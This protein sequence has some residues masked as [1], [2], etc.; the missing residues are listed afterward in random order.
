M[1]SDA[2]SGQYSSIGSIPFNPINP[3]TFFVDNTAHT[4]VQSYYYKVIAVD[5]C[6]QDS[7]TSDTV[8]TIYLTGKVNDDISNTLEFNDYEVWLGGVNHYSLFRTVDGVFDGN[9]ADVAKG[10]NVVI[11]DVSDRIYTDGIFC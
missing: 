1:R 7:Y 4:T 5:S 8:R 2:R 9:I 6:G 3:D 10:S 11:D